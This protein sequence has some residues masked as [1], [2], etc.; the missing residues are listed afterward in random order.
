M[1]LLEFMLD[2]QKSFERMKSYFTYTLLLLL[3]FSSVSCMRLD[4]NLF[5]PN[6]N[7]IK[8]YKFDSYN[9]ETDFRLAAPYQIPDG[10][11]NLFTLTS[12]APDEAS[13][14]KIYAV[15]IGNPA[16]IATDTVI[17]YCHG[18]KDH[19]DFY[20]PRAALLANANGKNHYGVLMVDYRGYGLSEGK[21]TE[22][23]LY[24]DVDAG[25][26]WLRARGLTNDR[27]VMYGFSLG[28]APATKLTAAPR[29]L[30]PAKLLLEA[31]FAS[32]GAMVQ[33][34]T[35]LSLPAPFFTDLQVNNAEEIKA[36][37]QPLFW[38][39]GTKDDFLNIN[40]QG[41]VVY[42]NHRG[43]FKE[44]RRVEGANHSTVPATAGFEAYL[45]MVGDF[46][47]R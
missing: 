24:A 26:Q 35:A 30:T 23:G 27:L 42:D 25:L 32:A 18:N 3:L 37:Q 9:G 21:P 20:W 31:P 46:I 28:S 14:T 15:Y 11:V 19:L 39:H 34:A 1:G 47:R 12:Q 8:E 4:D 6:A 16:R 45:K 22:K 10:L 33:D 5:N 41:Q 44:Q 43:R 29:S 36:V 7:K 40:T 38:I 13:A 2:T 17:M